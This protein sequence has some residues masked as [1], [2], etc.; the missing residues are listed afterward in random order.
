MAK[1]HVNEV[2]H[3][4]IRWLT[5]I[6]G[7]FSLIGGLVGMFTDSD[8]F[9]IY[10]ESPASALM[11][12]VVCIALDILMAVT[13]PREYRSTNSVVI[14]QGSHGT[15]QQNAVRYATSDPQMAAY[16]RQLEQKRKIVL[17]S[18][19]SDDVPQRVINAYGAEYITRTVKGPEG[20]VRTFF[21]DNP[22]RETL[23]FIEKHN[24]AVA[25]L[26]IKDLHAG[27]EYASSVHKPFPISVPAN[28]IRPIGKL[29][30]MDGHDKH[31]ILREYLQ[32]DDKM[33]TY[34]Y[35]PDKMNF[36]DRIK[37]D[38]DVAVQEFYAHPSQNMLDYMFSFNPQAG[39]RICN[40]VLSGQKP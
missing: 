38:V 15:V 33:K 27:L 37:A 31:L 18:L 7:W 5:R 17:D 32:P 9:S 12:G 2:R 1:I 19:K 39:D 24:P 20:N 22:S 25:A 4:P 28:Q 13:E 10:F 29:I 34:L 8:M 30:K 16:Y 3:G 21:R 14:P 6:C 36:C 40:E 26:L 35:Q 11:V 23:L